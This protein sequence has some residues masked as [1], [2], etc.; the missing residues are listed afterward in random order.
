[1]RDSLASVWRAM[2]KDGYE[3]PVAQSVDG[4]ARRELNPGETFDAMWMPPRPGVY[5]VRMISAT[6]Q[7]AYRRVMRVRP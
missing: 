3:L 4:A 6:G 7:V 2:A 5:Q 1:M